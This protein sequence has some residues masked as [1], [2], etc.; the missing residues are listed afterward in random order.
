MEVNAS[1]I[2][3]ASDNPTGCCP[4]FDPDGWSEQEL[5]FEDKL[6]VKAE[7]KSALHIPI[8]MG[9]V[10][11]RTFNAIE[12][13]GASDLEQS[14]ILSRDVSPW[15]GVHFFAV[16]KEVP[17]QEMARMS[18][19]FRTKVFE[20]AYR[21][22]PKWIESMEEDLKA[23]GETADEIYMFY[24]TCPKCAK[25]YGK[26]YVVAFAKTKPLPRAM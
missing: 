18:G 2:Y 11:E 22:A 25:T 19:D 24:T 23:R 3:D 8:N 13:A 1:P 12:A 17:G 7:T 9:R 21:D 14:L 15:K 20:G 16:T 10:F 26:N 5:H 6:F 4:R